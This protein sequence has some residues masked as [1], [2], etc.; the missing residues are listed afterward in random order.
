MYVALHHAFAKHLSTGDT[1]A[2]ESMFDEV[3]YVKGFENPNEA[4]KNIV[5]YLVKANYSDED[6]KKV[7]GGNTLRV[8]KEVWY[9]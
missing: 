7:M 2:K 9:K 8:R 1:K 5:R 4:A 6:I 3:E